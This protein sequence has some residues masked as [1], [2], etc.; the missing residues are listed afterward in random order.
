MTERESKRLRAANA[1]ESTEGGLWTKHDVAAF[2]NVDVRSV[3]RMPIP[4]VHLPGSGRRPI[5]RFDPEQVKAW[6]ESKRTR[7]FVRNDQKAAV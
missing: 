7:P 2:L 5:V 3:E 6:I 1:P 4:R